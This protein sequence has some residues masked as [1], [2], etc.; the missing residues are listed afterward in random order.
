MIMPGMNGPDLATTL[1]A[2]SPR[3]KCLYVSG[4][5]AD[6]ITH[7]GVLKEGM[8]FLQKPFA[9]GELAAKIREVLDGN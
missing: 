3:L 4:Y 9:I 1:L 6:V 7:R 8:H 5:T 2:L